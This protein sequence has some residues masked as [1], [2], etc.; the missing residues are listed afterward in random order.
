MFLKQL[1]HP[2]PEWKRLAEEIQP[3]L[4]TTKAFSYELLK[5]LAGV[6]I[7]TVRGRQQF[8]RFRRYALDEWGVWFE[9]ERTEGYRVVDVSET[10]AC[11][12]QRMRRAKRQNARALAITVKTRDE[13]ASA[14]VLAARRQLAASLGALMLA[15]EN[16]SKKMRPMLRQISAPSSDAAA[17]VERY[18]RKA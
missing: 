14:A 15:T 4:E 17:Q 5:A 8:E 11:S 16:E 13:G 3:L 18:K 12:M 9:C 1:A 6:D 2:H 7:R 10:P